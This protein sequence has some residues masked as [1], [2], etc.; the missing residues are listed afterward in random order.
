VSDEIL[1]WPQR[2]VG[3]FLDRFGRGAQPSPAR[4]LTYLPYSIHLTSGSGSTQLFPA[5]E[6]DVLRFHQRHHASVSHEVEY[7]T[8]VPE[9]GDPE[10]YLAYGVLKLTSEEVVA[11]T[12]LNHLERKLQLHY[13]AFAHLP[14]SRPLLH[15]QYGQDLNDEDPPEGLNRV[16]PPRGEQHAPGRLTVAEI[17]RILRTEF[18]GPEIV[19]WLEAAYRQPP[20]AGEVEHRYYLDPSGVVYLVRHSAREGKTVYRSET[21]EEALRPIRLRARGGDLPSRGSGTG[22]ADAPSA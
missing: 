10:Q 4:R 5:G 16:V 19:S 21:S 17:L 18:E 2:V 7:V 1:S 12:D 20:K 15:R 8:C 11:L 6:L 9:G 14:R 22:S 3:L 13:G